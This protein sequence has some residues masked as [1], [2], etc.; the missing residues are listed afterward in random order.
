MTTILRGQRPS[1][2]PVTLG[3]RAFTGPEDGDPTNPRTA[4]GAG[5]ILETFATLTPTLL[6]AIDLD[7]FF[8]YVNDAWQRTLGFTPDELYARPCLEFLHADD[9]ERL[10]R[11]L[12]EVASTG[13]PFFMQRARF[14]CRDGT[15]RWLLWNAALDPDRKLL[16]C[17]ARDITEQVKLERQRE[18]LAALIVH[19]LKSPLAAILVNAQHLQAGRSPT[20]EVIEVASDIHVAAENMR[21]MVLDLL[22]IARSEEGVLVPKPA[23]V[24]LRPLIDEVV[25]GLR[26]PAAAD[27]KRIVVDA[28]AELEAIQTDRELVRRILENLVDNAIRYAPPHS[29]VA[30]HVGGVGGTPASTLEV[31]VCDSGP[32]VPEPFR[33]SIFEK[34]VQGPGAPGSARTRHGLGLA[35]CRLAVEALGGWIWVEDNLPQGCCFCL[36]LPWRTA[37]VTRPPPS[38]HSVLVVED[39]SE[40]RESLRD[41]LADE[42]FCVEVASDGQEAMELLLSHRAEPDVILLDWMM[43]RMNGAQFL[44]ELCQ[45][46]QGRA[47]AVPIVVITAGGPFALPPTVARCLR[48]PLD[49][50]E[51]LT[52]IRCLT[53]QPVSPGPAGGSI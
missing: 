33:K 46:W 40:I 52:A 28:P 8:R 7:G 34:Y 42:G 29:A 44:Q 47:A 19:D 27:A 31:R 53:Q 45:R 18:E 1:Q 50:R 9:R 12:A 37:R 32:G 23:S 14:E 6:A 3:C 26:G 49:V 43:P 2:I 21:R 4:F 17:A 22:D 36:R 41:L 15:D 51:L 13:Q 30:I 38:A 16:F 20:E 11:A 24:A 35:F 10:S 48:K 25:H 5:E 39:D